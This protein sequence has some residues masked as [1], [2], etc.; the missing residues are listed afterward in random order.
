MNH[1]K[2]SKLKIVIPDFDSEITDLIIELNH[3]RRKEVRG[4]TEPQIFFQ[5]KNIFHS[6]ESIGSA[7]IEGNHTTI[8]EYIDSKTDNS[9]E[10]N[11]GIKEIENMEKALTFIEDTID[12]TPINRMYLSEIHKIVVKDLVREGSTSPGD[13]RKGN[14]SIS[15]SSFTPP[16][17]FTVND[18]MNELFDFI[19]ESSADKFD[20][21][22]TAISHHRFV[23]V[24]PYDNGNGRTVRLLTYA[25]LIKLGFNIKDGRILNPTAVFCFDR[26]KYYEQLSKA[27]SGTDE[28][29][30]EW[31]YYV[32][33][34]LKEEIEKIDRLLDYQFLK[35]EILLPAI[36][37]AKKMNIISNVDFE[38]LKIA[39]NKQ[40]FSNSDLSSVF[41]GK[42]SSEVSRQIKR[43]K[44]QEL[45]EPIEGSKQKYVISFSGNKL[46]RGVIFSLR[47]K[48]FIPESEI[49]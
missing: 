32:L 15:G 18:Y 28:G 47:E 29:I 26:E 12:S 46:L 24:H 22:K 6:L 27:D 8:A 31:C 45:I 9:V 36:K 5:I 17:Y 34:G 10:I 41:K 1:S 44:S 33:K 49:V 38:V 35:S 13:Y 39:I 19:N 25:M 4:S 30:L 2:E 48:G 11:E 16:D 23:W 42:K 37:H 21:L 43:M 7:R 20:L 40:V 14:I 3:L